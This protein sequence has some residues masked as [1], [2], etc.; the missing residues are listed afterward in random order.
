MNLPIKTLRTIPFTRQS[1]PRTIWT[2]PI[3]S[4]PAYL[5]VLR[6]EGFSPSDLLEN[7][8]R[9]T[10]DFPVRNRVKPFGQGTSVN[11]YPASYSGIRHVTP[12]FARIPANSRRRLTP[13]APHTRVTRPGNKPGFHVPLRQA[14]STIPYPQLPGG[15]MCRST[16]C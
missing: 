10:A 4:W 5:Q 3:A 7:H 8:L 14:N 15:A 13:R 2:I 9:N 11:T 1:L 12:N 6:P 16:P